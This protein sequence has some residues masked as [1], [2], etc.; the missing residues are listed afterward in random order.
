[1]KGTGQTLQGIAVLAQQFVM[2]ND[3]TA[4][5][6]AYIIVLVQGKACGLNVSSIMIESSNRKLTILS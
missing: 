5:L 6:A 1:M 4:A 2:P 3:S